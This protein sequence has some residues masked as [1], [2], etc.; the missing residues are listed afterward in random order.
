M[1]HITLFF[2]QG[3]SD[4]TYRAA[5]E[6]KDGGFVV[7]FQYG[8][9]GSALQSGTKTQAPVSYEKARVIYDRLV[10]EK[11]KGGYTPGADGVPYQQTDHEERATGIH[12][13]LLNPVEEDEVDRLIA[14]PAYWMSE[15]VDGVRR[16]V[17]KEG[18]IITGINRLGLAV[19]L[20]KPLY[21]DAVGCPVD[22]VIDGEAIGETLHAFDALQI[23]DEDIRGLGH[24]ER[25]VRLMNLLASFQHPTIQLVETAFLP[26]HKA[27]MF[28]RLRTGGAEGVVFK[29][30]DGPYT[31]GRPASGGPNRKHKFCATASFIV[32]KI[33]AKRSVSLLLFEGD[34]IKAAG[35]VTIPPNHE[36]PQAGQV[37]ECRFLYA[38]RESGSIYQGVF[39][40]ERDDITAAECITAQL[41]YRAEPKEEAAWAPNS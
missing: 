33:N 1:E 7:Q 16:L 19:A 20:P 39:L 23:G 35:N 8:R 32:G 12:C 25:Y 10:A 37:V 21:D 27:E 4:K 29:H 3:S 41:K 24:G 36:V 31:A 18:Q 28:S 17:R 30:T 22:F 5:I 2:R 38:L 40:G 6:P 34:K 15:K 14:D 11:A 13:Q 26:A 9:R